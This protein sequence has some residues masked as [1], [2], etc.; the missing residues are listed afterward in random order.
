[1][2]LATGN[3]ERTVVEI[4]LNRLIPLLISSYY[5]TVGSFAFANMVIGD[6]YIA[7]NFDIFREAIT[8][9][10]K[11][12]RLGPQLHK[13]TKPT[14]PDVQLYHQEVQKQSEKQASCFPLGEEPRGGKTGQRSLLPPTLPAR[15]ERKRSV[16]STEE[17]EM[18][19]LNRR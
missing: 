7:E 2:L 18:T 15:V 16:D 12:T 4:L 6:E 5:H 17:K 1:M 14:D 13:C 9:R 19:C 3:S 10:K 11:S 8:A